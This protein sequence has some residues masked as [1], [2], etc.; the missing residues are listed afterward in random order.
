MT[1]LNLSGLTHLENVNCSQNN[2]TSINLT[3]CTSL[4]TLNCNQ[5]SLASVDLTDCTNLKEFNC[6][7]NMLTTIDLST[8]P[9][10]E[11]LSAS[12]NALVSVNFN[13]APALKIIDCNYSELTS[14]DV[15]ALLQLEE[16]SVYNNQVSTLNLGTNSN[17]RY[18]EASDNML[19]TLD[20]TPQANLEYLSVG[21]NQL[22][23]L[24]VITLTHLKSFYCR[25]NQ[26]TELDVTNLFEV[27]NFDCSENQL[28]ALNLDNLSQLS[29]FDCV[30]N[31]LAGLDVSGLTNISS[32]NCS[33]NNIPSFDLNGLN[34]LS[35]LICLENPIDALD[36][37]MLPYLYTLSCGSEDHPIALTMGNNTNLYTLFIDNF[38]AT[39]CDFSAAPNLRSLRIEGSL[40]TDVDVSMLL[41]LKSLRIYDSPE[42][43]YVN[44]KNGMRYWNYMKMT[45]CPN[46]H[47]ICANEDNVAQFTDSHPGVVVQSYCTFLPGGIYNT[48]SGTFLFDANNNGCDASDTLI[49]MVKVKI[50]DGFSEGATFLNAESVYNFYTGAGNFTLTPV[51]ENPSYFNFA[52]VSPVAFATNAN[53]SAVRDICMTPNGIHPEAEV[54]IYASRARPG[55]DTTYGIVYT[56]NGNQIVDG[57]ITLTFDDARTDFISSFPAATQ[58]G[59][60]LVFNFSDLIPF[61]SRHIQFKLNLN[62][63]MET[64]P[65][66]NG[67]ILDFTA[68]MDYEI[69]GSAYNSSFE[70]HQTIVNSFDPN[71]KTCLEGEN[72]SPQMIGDYVHYNINFENI[73]TAPAENVVVKDV[74]DTT[75]FDISTLQL[76]Y[77]SHPVM[78]RVRDNIVEF[79]FQ[80][81]N[82]PGT[83]GANKGNV[84]FKIKTR[85]DLVLGNSISNK[86]EI[87]FDYNF[88]IETNEAT[89]TFTL[90]K[91]ESFKTDATIGIAP[92]PTKDKVN[93]KAQSAI[94][95]VQLFDLQGR[96]LQT[97]LESGKETSIDISGKQNGIYFLKVTTEKGS[98]VEKLIKE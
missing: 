20:L 93:I 21:T 44:A 6:T 30:Q 71:D 28:T 51:I 42:L 83:E 61:E 77:A 81:I 72:I 33:N 48:I 24:N 41:K 54:V 88:P 19:T 9:N 1:S 60:T 17:L 63:P 64:P 65:L 31:Q 95:S 27:T 15:S 26:L 74:I 3:G 68:N 97:S 53:L 14:V 84:V 56:N 47:S 82:L 85:P 13:A 12:Q 32:I 16:L 38:A 94:K 92:N 76:I 36:I 59:N 52:P 89:S 2:L 45:N 40:L 34:T 73:G 5:N 90:L 46:L 7:N 22:T 50:N 66:N 49:P 10:L 55:F 18:L 58:I 29:I 4:K 80:N 78:A 98:K 23:A 57:T 11:I 67:D 37:S 87:F 75:K 8:V 79:I 25:G 69:E 35:T 62:G 91:N 39:Q 43:T 96:L 70:L 86:A